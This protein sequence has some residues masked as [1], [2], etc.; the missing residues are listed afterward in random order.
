MA[1]LGE[2]TVSGNVPVSESFPNEIK[3]LTRKEWSIKWNVQNGSF[4]FNVCLKEILSAAADND[5]RHHKATLSAR[6]G[7]LPLNN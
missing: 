4:P 6:L 5:A 3:F 1:F 2:G 7:N